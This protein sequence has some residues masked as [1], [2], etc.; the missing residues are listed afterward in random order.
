MAGRK[1]DRPIDLPERGPAGEL[2]DIPVQERVSVDT[3]IERPDLATGNRTFIAAGGRV[4]FGLES[5]PRT[6]A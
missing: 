3:W 4:P 5:F 6:P 2:A 1:L